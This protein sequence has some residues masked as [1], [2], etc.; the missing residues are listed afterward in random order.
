MLAGVR[1]LLYAGTYGTGTD[2]VHKALLVDDEKHR[3][4]FG[5][6]EPIRFDRCPASASWLLDMRRRVNREIAARL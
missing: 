1:T 6:C 3:N 4:T 2:D 5:L